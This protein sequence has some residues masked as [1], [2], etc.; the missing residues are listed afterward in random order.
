MAVEAKPRQRVRDL[1]SSR[2][3]GLLASLAGVLALAAIPFFGSSY[4][5]S[6]AS[7]I[8]ILAVFAMSLG[9]L[10]GFPKL[11]SLGHAAFFGGG[12]Y[13]AGIVA[14]RLEADILLTMAAALV[15]SSLLAL[16]IGVLSLRNTGVYFLMI[17]LA[18]AQLV[19][20]VAEQWVSVTGGT[21]GLVGI[22]YPEL[23]GVFSFDSDSFYYLVLFFAVVTYLLLRALT[24]SPFGRVLVGIGSN[25]RRVRAIGYNPKVYKLV[26]F[27][28]AGTVAGG[29]GA[30]WGHF[31]GIVAPVDLNWPLSATA[32][33]MVIVGGVGTLIGPMLGAALVWFLDSGLSS[34]T[35]RSTMI[36]GVVFIL[37]VFFARRGVVGIAQDLW[38]RVRR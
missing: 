4:L 37:F 27:V 1:L 35:E 29:A 21:D 7:E 12:A 23:I 9:L 38:K 3:G 34:Y 11:V 13:A 15:F 6:V 28:I 25:E 36:M 5:V 14:V 30:L 31:N 33:I 18:L 19:Y 8:L 16:V 32:L 24:R 10:M 2:H 17:T 26:A 22:P 20:V